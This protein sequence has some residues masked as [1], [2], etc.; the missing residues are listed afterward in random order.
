MAACDAGNNPD[1]L[2]R[3]LAT[4][5]YLARP[6]FGPIGTPTASGTFITGQTDSTHYTVSPSQ[7]VGPATFAIGIG[8]QEGTYQLNNSFTVSS[9]VPNVHAIYIRR[10]RPP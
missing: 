5:V 10:K 6:V 3:R 7:L 8:A 4:V 1:S 2:L 9:P